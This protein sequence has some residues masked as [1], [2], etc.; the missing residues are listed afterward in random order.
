MEPAL[1]FSI[2]PAMPLTQFIKELD[3]NPVVAYYRHK[4]GASYQY[5]LILNH[6]D[7]AVLKQLSERIKD[8]YMECKILTERELLNSLDVFPMEFLDFK[9]EGELLFGTDILQTLKASKKNLRHELESHLRAGLLNLREAY[10]S[11]PDQTAHLINDSMTVFLQTFRYLAPMLNL[12]W[13]SNNVPESLRQ[14]G[15]KMGVDTSVLLAIYENLD[16]PQFLDARFFDYHQ[17]ITEIVKVVDE[18]R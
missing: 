10:V 3:P 14:L 4:Q 17:T 5:L 11:I 1:D 8:T 18:M 2:I 13:Q 16:R 7:M 6:I 9:R 12:K 15:Q